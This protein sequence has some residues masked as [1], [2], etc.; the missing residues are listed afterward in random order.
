MRLHK[1]ARP[2][3]LKPSATI[4]VTQLDKIHGTV[5]FIGPVVV[6]DAANAD[7]QENYTPRAQQG[8]H[9]PVRRTDISITMSGIAIGENTLETAPLLDHARE[10]LGSLWIEGRVE[11]QGSLERYGRR[12]KMRVR[13]LKG[14]TVRETVLNGNIVPAEDFKRIQVID[15]RESIKLMQTR[16]NSTIFNIRQAADMKYQLRSAAARC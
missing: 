10:E 2:V 13:R 8:H 11:S 6:F 5:V 16:D 7:I 3:L 14:A 9:A 4:A 1:Q 12:R 15:G